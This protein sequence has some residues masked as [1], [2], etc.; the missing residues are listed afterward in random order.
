MSLPGSAVALHTDLLTVAET[1]PDAAGLHLTFDQMARYADETLDRTESLFV[2]DHLASCLQCKQEADDLR[3][4]AGEDA[5]QHHLPSTVE[6]G[7]WEKVRGQFWPSFPVPTF[8]WA[9]AALLLITVAGSLIRLAFEKKPLMPQ[10]TNQSALSTVTPLLAITPS[11]EVIPLVA[12]LNDGDQTVT[13]DQHGKLS[14][15]EDLPP[16]YQHMVKEALTTQQLARPSSLEGLNRRGSSLMGG[17]E[18][19]NQFSL[20]A[21]AGKVVVADR[22]AFQWAPLGGATAYVVEIYDEQFTLVLKSEALQRTEWTPPQP[23]ARGHL[24]VWQVR[25][26]KDG[27]EVQA[28]KPPS[29]QARFRVLAQPQA[30]EIVRARRTYTSS[31]LTLGLLYVQAGLLDEAEQELRLLRK[32]N[33]DSPVVRRLL[34][35]VQG[36]RR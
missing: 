4:F 28:P 34:A 9:F 6:Q 21:P 30:E 8:G 31:H 11:T 32:A 19:G 14:G 33:P 22:P 12:Q 7:F 15:L 10:L 36:L 16:T 23:L 24:Y 18:Q 35:Q 17:D 20:L 2:T 5:P 1:L 25:A 3:S 29:P 27:Q 13:L 26:T